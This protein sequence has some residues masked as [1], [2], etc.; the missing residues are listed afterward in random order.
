MDKQDWIGS[1]VWAYLV[2]NPA[3][4]LT[5]LYVIVSGLGLLYEYVLFSKFGVNILDY[6]EAADFFLAAFKHPDI[7]L[8]SFIISGSFLFYR[9]LANFASQQNNIYLRIFLLLFCWLGLFRRE[10]LLP[11]GV[12]YFFYFYVVLVGLEAQNLLHISNTIVKISSES[13][14]QQKIRLI[15]IGTTEKFIF[16]IPFSDEISRMRQRSCFEETAPPITAIPFTKIVRIEYQ[17]SNEGWKQSFYNKFILPLK[18]IFFLP[19]YKNKP[20]C[21]SPQIKTTPPN[22][23]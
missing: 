18:K 8:L 16:G 5:T 1:K 22:P 12:V 17:N 7:F 14:K 21:P 15:P 9:V 11:L 2:A 6:S 23:T 20:P 10:V 3:F 4:L 13:D 19:R